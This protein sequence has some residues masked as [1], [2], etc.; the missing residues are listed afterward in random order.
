MKHPFQEPRFTLMGSL[1]KVTA[2]AS[3]SIE[4]DVRL[5]KDVEPYDPVL[6]RLNELSS[7]IA[8]KPSFQEPQITLAGSLQSITAAASVPDFSDARLKKDVEPY[9]SVLP[10]LKKL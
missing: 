2:A 4:S 10:R 6:P 5:K 7:P 8:T 3:E 1:Q 9:D